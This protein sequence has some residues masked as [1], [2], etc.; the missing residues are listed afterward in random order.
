MLPVSLELA[1]IHRL[2]DDIQAAVAANQTERLMGLHHSMPRFVC[3]ICLALGDTL[4]RWGFDL[5]MRVMMDKESR[6]LS[7][8]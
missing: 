3:R 4:I 7:F 1:V 5:K 6:S 8:S 2:E